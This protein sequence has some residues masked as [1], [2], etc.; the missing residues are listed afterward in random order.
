M[1]SINS[2]KAVFSTFLVTGIPGLEAVHIWISI[3]FST[4][5][6]ITLVGNVTILTVICRERTLHVPMYLFLAMLAVS[7]LGLSLFTFPTMLRI[8]WLDTRELTFSACFTQM[9]FIHTFQDFESAIILAM[10]FDRYVAISHPLR[11]SSILTSSAISRIGLAIV[12]R[13][14]TVQVPLPILL[15]RLC[16]CHSNVLSHSYCLHPDIIK[17]SCSN[18]RINSIFGLFV[19]LSTMGLDFLL[20]LFSYILILKTVLSIASSGGRLKALNTCISHICAVILFF[21]PMICLSILHRFGPK[22][23]SHIY[24]T[25]ANMHFL[26]PPVMNPIVYVAK[27]KQIRDKILKVFIKKEPESQVTFIT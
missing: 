22:L 14:L 21:T 26:I 7:D 10:A 3:P 8:F 23:P 15:R 5:F 19:V 12:V 11:Y 16:F 27:T 24:V 6:F 4:M 13:T 9:F 25:M 17:L 18:T 2:T 1:L 20:I